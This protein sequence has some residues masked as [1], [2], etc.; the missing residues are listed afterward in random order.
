MIRRTK[1]PKVCVDASLVLLWLIPEELSEKAEAL[2]ASWHDRNIELIAP[3]II[4][5]EVPSAI[6]KIVFYRKILPEIGEELFKVFCELDFRITLSEYLHIE[7]WELTKKFNLPG[8]YDM[9]YVA[10][11]K[12]EGCEFWTGDNRLVNATRGKFEW[13]K[14]IG[15]YSINK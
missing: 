1:M 14:Y 12:M 9:Y 15:D 6:R 11:A 13:V 4:L 8:V 2:W 10:L 5:A 7:A 3:P